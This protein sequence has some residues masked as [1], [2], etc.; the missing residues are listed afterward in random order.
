MSMWVAIK[1]RVVKGV[2]MYGLCVECMG[3]TKV[4]DGGVVV[5]NCRLCGG[6][7]CTCPTCERLMRRLAITASLHALNETKV[8]TWT[9]FRSEL[10]VTPTD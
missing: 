8:P 10:A 4:E 2:G 1:L 7:L 5:Y 6:E 3:V 9:W